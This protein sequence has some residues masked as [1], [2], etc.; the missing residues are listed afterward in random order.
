MKPK[1][2]S[3]L[4]VEGNRKEKRNGSHSSTQ[5]EKTRK[6]ASLL[7]D[8]L[9]DQK[10]KTNWKTPIWIAGLLIAGAL[11]AVYFVGADQSG[12]ISSSSQTEDS[13]NPEL[14]EKLVTEAKVAENKNDTVDRVEPEPAA[15]GQGG[16]TRTKT[17]KSDK[18]DSSPP[19]PA[20]SSFQST[21]AA[22][23]PASSR[24]ETVPARK[25]ISQESPEAL[26][27]PENSPRLIRDVSREETREEMKEDTV[28]SPP[29][30]GADP[31]A[32][33][34]Q[35]AFEYLG[36]N[37]LV[38]GSLING[39]Y[40]NLKYEGWKTIRETNQEVWV[41]IEASWTSGGPII[42]HIWSVDTDNGTIKALSQA[43]RNLEALKD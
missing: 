7:D 19:E 34:Q 25:D 9:S 11:T 42:H 30:P 43:A 31:R 6:S 32:E 4:L 10:R 28:E 3:N 39:G 18:A 37:S 12:H 33:R 40:D 1:D 20:S 41:D 16:P 13:R 21:P 27:R 5:E 17:V 24:Q 2:L 35:K 14:L 8:T 23:S 29:S 26:P 22:S 15:P 38:A 36:Q